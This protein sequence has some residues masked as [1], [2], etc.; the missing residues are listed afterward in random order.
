[1]A[2]ALDGVRIVDLTTM[3]SGPIATMMLADQ[4]ADV[5]KVEPKTGDLVRVLGPAK[6]DRTATFLAANRNKRSLV[7]DLKSAEGL[8]ALKKLV[9]TADVVVQNFRPGAAERM[10]IGEADLRKEQPNLIYVSISGF[11][12]TGPYAKKRV[13]DPVIQALS[14]LAA[15]QADRDT[16]RPRMIRTIIP[17]KLTAVTA[18]QAITAALFARERSGEGQHIK[19]SMLDAMIAFLW[20]EGLV[21][22]TFPGGEKH[23][24]R[25]Q[26]SQDLIYKTQDGYITVGA[27]SDDEWKGLCAALEQPQWLEDERFNT[28]SGRVVNAPAR[29]ALTQEVLQHKTSAEWLS[30][31]DANQVPCAPILNRTTLLDHPQIE[32]NDIIR[33]HQEEDLGS[34]RLPRP[35]ARFSETQA[36]IQRQAPHLGEHTEQLLTELGYDQEAVAD[37]VTAA[38]LASHG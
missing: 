32:A 28:P 13:Y 17:D 11:G 29:L 16:G 38:G 25:A 5:I 15:I 31:L 2:G 23:A 8:E 19:L 36:E 9:S 35:A 30:V 33:D 6:G 34:F 22:L 26:L 12:E 1:M 37:F 7:L 27:V 10:G 18:A 21:A 4:G 24:A 3:I 14:G 20:A